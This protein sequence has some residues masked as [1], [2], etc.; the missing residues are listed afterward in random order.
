MRIH[1]VLPLE[2]SNE[3]GPPQ[4]SIAWCTARPSSNSTSTAI[5]AA[6]PSRTSASAGRLRS[7]PPVTTR[8]LPSDPPAAGS[9]ASGSAAQTTPGTRSPRSQ[10]SGRRCARLILRNRRAASRRA[11]TDATEQAAA[12]RLRRYCRQ[13][14]IRHPLR[15]LPYD[16]F[17]NRCRQLPAT[18]VSQVR[19]RSSRPPSDGLR[20]ARRS[21]RAAADGAA[22]VRWWL[23]RQRPLPALRQ[24]ATTHRAVP[25]A[26]WR[27]SDQRRS[28]RSMDLDGGPAASS[29]ACKPKPACV[30]VPAVATPIFSS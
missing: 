9:G 7:R 25:S 18:S 22:T 6:P 15:R 30:I 12:H 17:P 4:P 5:G 26:I 13:A 27:P 24:P 8:P 3:P 16:C 10:P 20:T 28:D 1:L 11:G 29:P 23:L 2:L 21:G 19:H 14:L